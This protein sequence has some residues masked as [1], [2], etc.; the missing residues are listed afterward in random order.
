MISAKLPA[1]PAAITGTTPRFA[2]IEYAPPAARPATQY[3]YWE[4]RHFDRSS[5]G[6][7]VL[8]LLLLLLLVELLVAALERSLLL[9]AEVVII[10]W[11]SADAA[12]AAEHHDDAASDASWLVDPFMVLELSG[13]GTT[14][15]PMVGKSPRCSGLGFRNFKFAR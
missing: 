14:P 4:R 7:V 8:L 11:A 9:E 2:F 10:G 15:D 13:W 6:S 5:D 3:L 12:A 1:T